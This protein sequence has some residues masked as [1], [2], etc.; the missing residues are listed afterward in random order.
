MGRDF[1]RVHQ[2]SLCRALNS[3]GSGEALG[4]TVVWEGRLDQQWEGCVR[5]GRARA[6]LKAIAWAWAGESEG[7]G[8]GGAVRTG[9]G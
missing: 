6:S 2:G 3:T 1:C 9:M 4:V 8:V 7:P 5:K